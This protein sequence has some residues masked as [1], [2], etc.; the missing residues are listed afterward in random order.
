MMEFLNQYW[1]VNDHLTPLELAA[2]A[3][4]MFWL[5]FLMIRFSGM[6][7]FRNHNAFDTVIA[8]LLGGI[9]SRGVVGAT[10]F[11]STVAGGLVIVVVN[12][13][14]SK[15]CFQYRQVEKLIKGHKYLLYENGSFIKPNML[16]TEVTE[17]EIFEELRQKCQL[18]SLD[19]IRQIYMEKTGDLS[20]VKKD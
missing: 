2:R 1:G 10:P 11:F 3:F 18:D 5:A 8:V 17:R 13:L 14:I 9:L 16:K 6:R 12:K 20:F 15:L 7:P 19:S 4:V